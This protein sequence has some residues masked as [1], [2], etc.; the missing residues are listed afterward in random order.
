LIEDLL[1]SGLD[2][3]VV[4]VDPD[5]AP[6]HYTGTSTSTTETIVVTSGGEIDAEPVGFVSEPID[7]TGSV[8]DDGDGDGELGS[9]EPGRGAITITLTGL[10]YNG[11]PVTVTTVTNPD[12]SYQ[13]ENVPRPGPDGFTVTLDTSTLDPSHPVVTTPTS[14]TI[15]ADDINPDTT[16]VEVSPFG[17]MPPSRALLP[18]TG[19]DIRTR[20]VG[21]LLLLAVGTRLV[22]WTRPASK[23]RTET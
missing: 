22:T 18:F 23:A 21:S 11:D 4:T 7:I 5:T 20:L 12:G 16:V 1:P 13:F 9:G 19:T 6:D 15:T 14:F 8:F 3:Y 17:A 10:D 2:G